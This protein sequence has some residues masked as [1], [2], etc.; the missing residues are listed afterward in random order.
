MAKL[1]RIM[2]IH[3][4]SW[5][6]G[7]ALPAMGQ[8]KCMTD[9]LILESLSQNDLRRSEFENF[10]AHV[11]ELNGIQ[12]EARQ[13]AIFHVPVVFH[14]VY[15][16]SEENIPDSRVLEQLLRLNEDFAGENPD[17]SLLPEQFK[18]LAGNSRIQFCLAT[19]DPTG[20]ISPG[21][22]RT[23][24]DLDL[25]GLR[26][27]GGRRNVFYTDLGGKNSWDS[28]KYLNIYIADL[29][30][31]GGFAAMPFTA[32]FPEEDAVVLNFRYVGANDDGNFS[33][34]RIC[35]HE[36]GHFLGLFHPWGL[37]E[38][39]EMDDRVQD[40][41]RQFGPYFDCPNDPQFSCGS[42]DLYMNFMGF[43]NDACMHLFTKGQI[44]R[45][46][47]TL[48]AAR[49]ELFSNSPCGED[50]IDMSGAR[51]SIFPNPIQSGSLVIQNPDIQN[52]ISSI[53]LFE[54]G[55]RL[56]LDQKTNRADWAQIQVDHI[57]AGVYFL[58]LH[59]QNGRQVQ[60][61]VKL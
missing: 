15:N 18:H 55:G 12:T 56:V 47:A 38:G 19:A 37:E 58:I 16:R 41:P 3:F 33:L 29:G 10:L 57:S 4:A 27:T 34:G 11:N 59:T 45:M 51:I 9:S 42:P 60:R 24:T 48:I 7:G 13:G 54:V 6:I 44:N 61:L 5:V 14:I 26:Q 1:C 35:T 21:I 23:S 17:R 36:V 32:T 43:V 52:P 2:I 31:I 22:T 50:P 25:I 39:C 28:K 49:P 20:A 46:Q 30:T 8:M 53:Q 40:T